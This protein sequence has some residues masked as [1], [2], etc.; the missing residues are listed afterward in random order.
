VS[1]IFPQNDIR[2]VLFP[3]LILGFDAGGCRACDLASG[4][5]RHF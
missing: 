5:Q 2:K 1:G 4:C 3:P